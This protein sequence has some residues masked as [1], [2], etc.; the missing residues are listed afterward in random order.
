MI[1]V[2]NM[3]ITNRHFQKMDQ[4]KDRISKISIVISPKNKNAIIYLMESFKT[5][6]ITKLKSTIQRFY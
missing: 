5:L 2:L 6:L 1:V 3:M 4:L